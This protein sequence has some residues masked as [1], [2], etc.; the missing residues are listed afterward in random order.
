MG[1]LLKYK[2]I[3]YIAA[4]ILIG[5]VAYNYFFK[6]EINV[7]P[8]TSD[9]SSG[10]GELA[11][12]KEI[13]TLLGDLHS[14]VLDSSI[15]SSSAFKSLEDFSLPVEDEPKGRSNPFAPIGVNVVT[16]S[17]PV[18]D[19]ETQTTPPVKGT[20]PEDFLEEDIVF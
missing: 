15:F 16:P 1:E 5:L 8:V 2:K 18:K 12:D 14:L 9:V 17:L 10:A 4:L 7:D 3:I 13:L 19:G 20:F 6:P 11:V